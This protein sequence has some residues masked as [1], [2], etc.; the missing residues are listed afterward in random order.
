M[1]REFLYARGAIFFYRY[2]YIDRG[3]E[4]ERERAASYY[5]ITTLIRALVWPLDIM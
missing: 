4:R 3:R 2:D 1:Y 5:Y